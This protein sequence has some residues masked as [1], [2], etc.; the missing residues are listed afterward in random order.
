[1][2][3]WGACTINQIA[4]VGQVNVGGGHGPTIEDGTRSG[5]LSFG[6]QAFDESLKWTDES[7]PD[8]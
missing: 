1:M 6:G 5:L 4:P 3:N 7:I 8:V 2:R